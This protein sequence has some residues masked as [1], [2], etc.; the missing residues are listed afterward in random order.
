MFWE[1]FAIRDSRLTRVAQAIHDANLADD[2]F[3]RAEAL[4]IDRVLGWMEQEGH[5]QR[6][7]APRD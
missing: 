3:G 7:I 1:H 6:C 4:G 5:G 2:K